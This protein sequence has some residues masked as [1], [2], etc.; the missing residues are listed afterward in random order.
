M[1]AISALTRK[2]RPRA[3]TMYR[4][5]RPA[6]LGVEAGAGV[7]VA[8]ADGV[9]ASVN[10]AAGGVGAAAV[11]VEVGAAADVVAGLDAAGASTIAEETV[12]V[13]AARFAAV[14]ALSSI[15]ASVRKLSTATRA[16]GVIVMGASFIPE[17]VVRD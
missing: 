5:A 4:G 11:G 10:A 16:S 6:P 8:L 7:S 12:C 1:A 17:G 2:R 9:E 3:V 14:R 13:S 15:I